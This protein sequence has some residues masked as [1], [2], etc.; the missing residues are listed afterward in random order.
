M[1]KQIVKIH[2]KGW[3]RAVRYAYLFDILFQNSPAIKWSFFSPQMLT[4]DTI[5]P[6]A[7]PWR[8]IIIHGMYLTHCGLVM[9]FDNKDLHQLF[10][11]GNMGNGLLPGGT[12]PL[13]WINVDL[14]SSVRFSG[15][16]L[17]A[18]SQKISQPYIPES[19]FKITYLNFN[20]NFPG[21]NELTTSKYLLLE[22]SSIACTVHMIGQLKYMILG[23]GTNTVPSGYGRQVWI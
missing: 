23:A 2:S 10:G 9:P 22:L 5:Y 16:H 11:S 7:Y 20:S 6:I 1:W 14:L 8:G 19:S 17:K 21:A 12:K 18:I 4:I 13:T 15:I 3:Q